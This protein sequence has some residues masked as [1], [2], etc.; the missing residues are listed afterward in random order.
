M[1][2]RQSRQQQQLVSEQLRAHNFC[3]ATSLATFLATFNNFDRNQ[4]KTDFDLISLY[5]DVDIFAFL[6]G[7]DVGLLGFQNCF[8]VGLFF[9]KFGYFFLKL[10]SNTDS[11][12]RIRVAGK[13][14]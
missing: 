11:N 1:C 4:F 7:F 3:L 10:S 8:D 6:K 9:L 14:L 13:S 5:F 12:Q 2:P